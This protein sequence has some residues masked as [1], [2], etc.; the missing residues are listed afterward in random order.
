MVQ[1]RSMTRRAVR[2]LTQ[3]RRGMYTRL[4]RIARAYRQSTFTANRNK[5]RA[6]G[7][8]GITVQHDSRRIYKKRNMPR[9]KKKI[10]KK[11]V[12]K[13]NFIAEKELG[14]RTVL[15]NTLIDMTDTVPN[16]QSVMTLALY[17]LKSTSTHLNDLN[18]IGAFENAGDPTAAAGGT[19]DRTSHIMF[20]SA[21]LD[22]TI[23]NTCYKNVGVVPEKFPAA[24]AQ[25]ELDIYEIYCRN[26]FTT[27]GANYD[28]LALGIQNEMNQEKRIGGGGVQ[29]NINLRGV[30]PFDC[31]TALSRLG[32]KVLKKTKYFIPNQNTITYQIRDPKR[33][34][35]LI[36]ELIDETGC[37]KPKWTR[38][39]LVIYKLVPEL[40]KG[41]TDGTY[42]E[43]IQ[44]G[45]TRKY[46][47]KV[48]GQPEPRNRYGTTGV[49]LTNPY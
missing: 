16:N 26:D 23:R 48:E 22:L 1:T 3:S 11:F 15:F 7:G 44:V 39:L 8:Y 4:S 47:Y 36:R 14:T 45:L 19:V 30:T 35:C 46:M 38:F 9:R 21:V 37:N 34:S 42:G 24:E 40:T 10:W 17:P 20:Q 12:R 29:V 27:S 18:G 28:S 5:K 43:Q 25:L 31:P 41:T 6:H 33:R 2:S 49:T 32:M 13:V